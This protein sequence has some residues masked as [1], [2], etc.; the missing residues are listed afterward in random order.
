MHIDLQ[1]KLLRVLETGEFIKVG[2]TKTT[3]IN[4]RFIAATNRELQ[5]EVQSG[6]FRED[7]FYR[8]NVFTIL[9]PPLRERID[10]IP[11]L[12]SHFLRY[13]SLK[14]NKK[15]EFFSKEALNKLENHS[16]KG[17]IRE[18]KNVIERSTILTDNIAISP[19]ELIIEFNS[20]TQDDNLSLDLASIEKLHIRKVLDFAKGNKTKAAEILGIG[21]TTLYRKMEDYMI[22]SS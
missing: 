11:L 22:Q 18:L 5:K 9:L 21:L 20:S 3:Q 16:W 1:A 4:V 13:Y 19:H 15:I 2:D 17:N 10:D 7:L 12:A 14:M 6:K 8:L